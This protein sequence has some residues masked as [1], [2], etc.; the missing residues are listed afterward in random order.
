MFDDTAVEVKAISGQER[1]SVRI[2]SEDQLESLT[3]RLFLT[4]VRLAT[5]PDNGTSL[6]EL[7]ASIENAFSEPD[8]VDGFVGKLASYGYV[9]MNEYDSPTFN[10][11]ETRFFGV[12]EDFPKLIRSALPQGI[13]RVSYD[14]EI[15]SLIPFE[16]DSSGIFRG[17]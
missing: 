11:L 6:N 17:A 16:C 13:A 7:V 8:A 3:G 14:L 1:N 2:S 4:V 5:S 9:P 12:E 15:E 10:V